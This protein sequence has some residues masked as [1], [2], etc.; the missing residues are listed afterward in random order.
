MTQ[1]L[2]EKVCLVFGGTGGIGLSC[3]EAFAAA[4]ADALFIVGRNKQRGQTTLEALKD[5]YSDSRF[6]FC[7][8]DASTIEGAEKA[9]AE[10]IAAFGRIDI[11]LMTGGGD[12]MPRLF[13]ECEPEDIPRTIQG[14]LLSAILPSRAVIP[15][16]I[17]QK[18]GVILTMASDAGKVTTPGE[19]VVGAAMA[20]VIMFT[21]ALANEVKRSGI[22][23]NCISPSI[24][25]NTSLY[26]KL[27]QDPFCNKLFSKAE[28]MAALGVVEPEDLANLAVYLA[29][30]AAGKLSGQAISLNGGISMS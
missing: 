19:T 25:K 22:R 4:G 2:S 17:N 13:H 14:S 16:M 11:L 24:V 3:V 10:C 20:G 21:R 27:M 5:K 9:T 18:S 8:A 28:K 12:P 29:S 1:P 30:P 23:V 7:S 15:H 6:M 26:S